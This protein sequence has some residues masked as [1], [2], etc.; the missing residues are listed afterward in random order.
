MRSNVSS[1]P[2]KYAWRWSAASSVQDYDLKLTQVIHQLCGLPCGADNYYFS[3]QNPALSLSLQ[4]LTF[5]IIF[6][7]GY[8]RGPSIAARWP[9]LSTERVKDFHY[10]F[11][12]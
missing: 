2:C 9:M 8:L 12:A 11:T 7:A 6:M 5:A 10:L 3:Q 1:C 4:D